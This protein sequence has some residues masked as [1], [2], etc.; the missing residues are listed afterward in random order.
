MY[1]IHVGDGSA[2]ARAT[3][4]P[5]L[6]DYHAAAAEARNLTLGIAEPASYRSHEEHRSK[7]RKLTFNDLVEQNRVLVGGAAEVCDRVR[8]VKERLRLTDLAG[9]FALGNLPDAATR[10]ALRR[11]MDEVAPHV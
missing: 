2:N 4:E 8:Y 6:A 1:H 11:F 10:V 9:N 3:A 7:M 5:A